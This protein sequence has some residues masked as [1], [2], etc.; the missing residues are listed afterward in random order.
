MWVAV[1]VDSDGGNHHTRP[2]KARRIHEKER[3]RVGIGE[4]L[5]L[6]R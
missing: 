5:L 1:R 3:G 6:M 2:K 4:K